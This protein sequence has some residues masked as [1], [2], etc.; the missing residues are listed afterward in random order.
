MKISNIVSGI[1]NFALIAGLIFWAVQAQAITIR[2]QYDLDFETQL[3]CIAQNIYHEA[4]NESELG[5]RAVAWVT[6]NRVQSSAYPTTACDVVFQA[7]LDGNGNPIKNKCQ[8]SWFCDGKTDRIS[9]PE[10][11]ALSIL[12][13]SD[14]MMNYSKYPDPT[15]KAIMYHAN[16]VKPAWA[17][18][19]KRVVAIDA[20][21]FYTDK[22]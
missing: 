11:W 5:M 2:L 8:F 7:K 20:H 12:V 22:N 9:N 10:K 15:G 6:L 18:E 16:Y 1:L 3:E 17:S 21:I 4:R 13:A 19:Y 14:V